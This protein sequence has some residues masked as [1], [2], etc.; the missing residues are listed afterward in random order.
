MEATEAKTF[1]NE[2]KKCSKTNENKTKKEKTIKKEG[3]TCK[4]TYEKMPNKKEIDKQV[5]YLNLWKFHKLVF[6]KRLWTENKRRKRE[7][8]VIETR[9][10]DAKRDNR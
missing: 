1:K 6:Q 10:H 4:N 7:T 3:Q 8:N 5:F 2:N 9:K